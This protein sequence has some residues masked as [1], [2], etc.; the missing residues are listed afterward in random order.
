MCCIVIREKLGKFGPILIAQ[1]IRCLRP[2]RIATALLDFIRVVL[3]DG[4]AYADCDGALS[5]VAI[6]DNCLADSTP[7]VPIYF[8][9]S[10]GANVMGDLDSLALKYGFVAGETYHNVSMGQGQDVVAMRNLE[11]AHRQG[12]WVVLNNVH[13]MPRW[14]IELEKKLDEFALEGSNKKVHNYVSVTFIHTQ[15]VILFLNVNV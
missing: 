3:P 6:L 7:T 5:S 14:L 10:P 12:H 4:N 1:V 8:I 9:L 15:I 2:D 11:M 13:L